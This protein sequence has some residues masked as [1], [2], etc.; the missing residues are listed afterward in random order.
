MKNI[1]IVLT[2]NEANHLLLVFAMSLAVIRQT[3]L[4]EPLKARLEVQTFDLHEIVSG[5]INEARKEK[6]T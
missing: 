3:K 4:S 6:A 2:Q 1:T 5:A